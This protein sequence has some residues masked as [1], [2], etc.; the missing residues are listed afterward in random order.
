MLQGL[1]L[2]KQDVQSKRDS[3]TG[4]CA[5][6]PTSLNQRA[7]YSLASKDDGQDYLDAYSHDFFGFSARVLDELSDQ[8]GGISSDKGTKLDTGVGTYSAAVAANE[9]RNRGADQQLQVGA[10]LIFGRA[11]KVVAHG[12]HTTEQSHGTLGAALGSHSVSDLASGSLPCSSHDHQ[13]SP[14]VAVTPSRHSVSN[15]ASGPFPCSSRDHQGNPDAV[16]TSSRHFVS[17]ST[18]GP[19]PCSSHDHHLGSGTCSSDLGPVSPCSAG[20]GHVS[21]C[22]VAV[23]VVA[24]SGTCNSNLDHV[25]PCDAAVHVM[26]GSGTGSSDLGHVSSCD[27]AEHVVAGSPPWGHLGAI[28]RRVTLRNQYSSHTTTLGGIS[29]CVCQLSRVCA[30]RLR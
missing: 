22:D 10:G 18:P 4:M 14:G 9:N 21:L 2:L 28:Q 3:P 30:F 1:P 8:S 20:L 15:Y 23:H 24:G 25:S 7:Y 26:A 6:T 27:A 29:F 11:D 13:L 19:L 5:T 17:S 16:A 12:R